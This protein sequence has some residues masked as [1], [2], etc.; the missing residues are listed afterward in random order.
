MR[1]NRFWAD[2]G[3]LLLQPYD[4]EVGAGTFHPATFLRVLGPE[5]W[6]VAYVE[7]SRRPTDGRYGENPNRLQHYY[8]YQVILKPSPLQSQELY[9]E[10]LKALGLDPLKHDIRF[11][12]DD[13]ES[14]TLGAWG[15]GWEVWLDGM[16][17]TQ[18]TYFQQAGGIDLK[19]VSLE[20]TYGLERI[21]MYLQGVDNVFDIIWTRGIRYR[22]LHHQTEVE[23]SRFNF[24]LSDPHLLKRWFDDYE[25]ESKRLLKEGLVLPS[26]EFC[27]KCSH[28][29]NLLDARGVLSVTERTGYIARVRGLAKAVA[30]AYLEQRSTMGFPLSGQWQD[31]ISSE[32]PE[33]THP[34]SSSERPFRGELLFEIGTEEIPARFIPSAIKQLK[35]NARSAFNQMGIPYDEI[36]TFATPRRLV[37][38]M[39]GLSERQQKRIKKVYGPPAKVA[40]DEKGRPTRAAEGF[41]RSVGV[42]TEALNRESTEKGEYVYVEIH[43][44][45]VETKHLLPGI[46]KDLVL[47]IHFP[48][49]MRWA[50]GDLRFARPIHWFVAILDGEV[51]EFEV[52]G[53]RS[54]NISRGHRFLSPEEFRVEDPQQYFSELKK[55]YVVLDQY[56]RMEKILSDAEALA[57][58]RAGMLLK[59]EELLEE[60][61]FLVEY[62]R[63]VLC[64]F[65]E[66]YLTLPKELLVTVMKDH[67]RYFAVVNTKGDLL[68][69]FVV[70]SNTTED[71]DSTVRE[72]AERV[73]RA[74]FEDAR[75]YYEEDT[76]RPLIERVQELKGVIYHEKL[77]SLYDKTQRILEI[78]LAI[79]AR[80]GAEPEKVKRASLLCKA[81][82]VTGV[83][84][85]FPELQGV[86]GMYYC[87]RDEDPEVARAVYEHYLPRH[88]SDELPETPTGTTV[89]IADRVDTLVNF[90]S[91]GL[92]PTG[93]EDP[94]ALRRA[95]L[96]IITIL[97]K[98]GI[99]LPVEELIDT[100]V[101][102][103]KR[104]RE[105]LTEEIRQFF[106]QR[107]EHFFLSMGYPHDLLL[108]VRTGL[109]SRSL[110]ATSALLKAL[111]EF[112]GVK[113]HTPL[114][115]AI[116]RAFNILGERDI[117]T[118]VKEH[119][120]K[121][122]QERRLYE[123]VKSLAEILPPLITEQRY[124]E[125]LLRCVQLIEP[126]NEFFDNVLVM[127]KDPEVRNNRLALLNKLREN[128]LMLADLSK[129]TEV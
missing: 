84:R 100:A 112:R 55:R 32:K 45:G 65:P 85:E 21:A 75:F 82:L 81:D 114:T 72:G 125:A 106:L 104:Q 126:I 14:P 10:S 22:E 95:A 115:V 5:P 56:E 119:L 37:L 71:N 49:T 52:D 39:K 57:G 11:V 36:A 41:A 68:N 46:L 33:A 2:R 96:G 53:I 20:I 23:F 69:S 60:V 128:I 101:R 64:S 94:F 77:G 13:W 117:P 26:Y 109:L 91:V 103:S 51:I 121:E 58:S 67:Q 107:I 8:Q 16:E 59:D 31:E 102:V 15:L 98:K 29:F 61:T 12:E 73:I 30:E 40:F 43:E 108:A 122:P 47:S 17:I 92:K 25:R 93:S 48:K 66:E 123:E 129:L 62:P 99:D 1:L 88:A 86:M 105:P 78:G 34:G 83:V 27:L 74:R 54:G 3:C 80:T 118:E 35:E 42:S 97:L 87:L 9:L 38:Y 24:D 79:S 113:E 44:G 124:D 76:K 110:G 50:D 90:F 4:I 7:P 28:T 89:A 70:V 120:L 18:F 127:D 63:A 111:R 116:K 19:P 6:R